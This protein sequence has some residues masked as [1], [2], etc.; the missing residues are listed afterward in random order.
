[1]N[2]NTSPSYVFVNRVYPPARGATGEFLRELAEGL[3]ASGA[4][5]TVLTGAASGEAR[6]LRREV[7]N[8]VRIVRVWSPPHQRLSHGRRALGYAVLYPQLAWQVF[9]MGAV[10]A[11]I[12]MTD[13][14]LLVAVVTFAAVRARKRFHW[15]QDIYPEVA[16]VLGVVKA[17]GL[18]AKLLRAISRWALRR[19]NKVVVVGRC[20]DER[21]RARG[22]KAEKIK[23]IPNW[24]LADSEAS[25]VSAT[26]REELGWGDEF[27]AL[28]SGNLGLAHDLETLIEAAK[29]L[30]SARVR[31]VFAG[32]GPRWE[33]TKRAAKDLLQVT[34]LPPQPREKLGAFLAAA[35]AH[36]VS[37]R[38]GLDG[39]VVPSKAYGA[40]ASGRPVAYV[41][42][43]NSEIARLVKEKGIGVAVENGDAMALAAA[44]SG[45]DQDRAAADALGKRAQHTAREYTLAAALTKWREVLETH[46]EIERAAN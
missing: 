9:R 21:M 1:M 46:S 13:P 25:G 27:V 23:I 44:L 20:M 16:E 35:D 11:V 7:I 34:F 10:D 41:G 37:V 36:L 2:K 33:E 31:M 6:G 19:Q 22:V 17:G 14:P 26:M 42:P 28:Y 8:G 4:R 5:V 32:E 43:P 12:S 30:G 24:S 3:A 15:A 39:L 45:W 29:R 18:I 38:Q 40:M